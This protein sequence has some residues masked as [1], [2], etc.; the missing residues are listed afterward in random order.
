[1]GVELA[2]MT[3]LTH[4]DNNNKS[5]SSDE[6]KPF[7]NA[8]SDV[9]IE[10]F[11]EISEHYAWTCEQYTSLDGTALS[12]HTFEK[13]SCLS[14]NVFRTLRYKSGLPVHHCSSK[15]LQCNDRS[16]ICNFKKLKQRILCLVEELN[17]IPCKD[18]KDSLI[19]ET[20]ELGMSEYCDNTDTQSI[21]SYVMVLS[22]EHSN[23]I[24]EMQWELC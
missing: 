2:Q 23:S 17:L 5:N 22:D 11:L 14:R 9:I 12:V 8:F 10:Y 19:K 4:I 21:S 13:N 16:I 20:D 24:S 6:K 18:R 15:A 7:P 3:R 1:M